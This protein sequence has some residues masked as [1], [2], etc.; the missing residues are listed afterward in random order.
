VT[1][2]DRIEVSIIHPGDELTLYR[3]CRDAASSASFV[4]SFARD[5]LEAT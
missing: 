1:G 5:C 2:I 3:V 4:S